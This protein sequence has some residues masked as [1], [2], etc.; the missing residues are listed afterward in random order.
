MQHLIN[1][2]TNYFT[3]IDYEEIF[4]LVIMRLSQIILTFVLLVIIRRLVDHFIDAYFERLLKLEKNTAR[5]RTMKTLTENLVQYTYY[6]ILG[7][8]LLAA[9]GVPIATLIAGAGVASL[10]IGLGAQGFVNDLV[11][12]FFILFEHQF[13]VGDSVTI[14]KY[15]GEIYKMGIRTTVIRDWNGAI[16]FIPNRNITDIT[17][18]SRQPMRVDVDL[19]IYPGTDLD[20][21]IQTL[22]SAYDEQETDERLTKEPTFLGIFKDNRGRLIY[23]V[24]MFAVNGEQL[25][26]EGDYYTLFTNA[27]KQAGI[28]QPLGTEA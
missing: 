26:V 20:L 9:I 14:N 21:L 22:K 16:H 12:G 25:R 7:Y 5:T 15:S 8:S 28:E 1:L 13:D 19:L 2:V 6:A 10:A 24:R 4:G 27:L 18:Q 17:N 23:R 11:N 3:A